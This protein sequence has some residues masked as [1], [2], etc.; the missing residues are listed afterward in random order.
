MLWPLL[1]AIGGGLGFGC[2]SDTTSTTVGDDIEMTSASD[3][4]RDLDAIL[5]RGRGIE[6]TV[7]Q[8]EDKVLGRGYLQR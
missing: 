2:G 3:G 1:I 5:P 7:S 4:K 6:S 8:I